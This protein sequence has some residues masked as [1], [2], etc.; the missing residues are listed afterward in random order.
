MLLGQLRKKDDYTASHAMNVCSL[1]L[2]FGRHLG[3]PQETLTDIG[4]G[5]MLID[6]GILKIPEQ[7]LNKEGSLTQEEYDIVKHHV[8]YGLQILESAGED[9]PP[10]ALDVVYTHH[11]RCDGSG[12]PRGL[13]GDAIPLSGRMVGI[14]DTYDAMTTNRV[15]QDSA[16]PTKTLRELYEQRD[17]LFDKELVE[18]FIQFLGI[19]PVGTLVECSTGQVGMVI[20]QN[21]RKRLLPKLLLILDK[22]K[23]PYPIPKITDLSQADPNNPIKISSIVQAQDYDIDL[24]HYMDDLSWAKGAD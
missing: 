1:T 6:I 19:Y 16:P 14:V 2:A 18:S 4:M 11:E 3:L 12:Y 20:A 7:I 10:A 13:T 15:H 9:I 5:A 8:D 21:S 23:K 24:N 22:D 17:G